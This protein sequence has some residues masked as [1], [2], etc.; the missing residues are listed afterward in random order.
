MTACGTPKPSLR[1]HH[2]RPA[3]LP[4][5]HARIFW[6]ESVKLKIESYCFA[7][8]IMVVNIF[9]ISTQ[10]LFTERYSFS[11]RKSVAWSSRSQYF[12][13]A[14]SFKAMDIFDTKSA[15]LWPCCASLIFAPILVPLRRSCLE[16]T[17]SCLSFCICW[18][19]FTLLTAKENAFS[20]TM[21]PTTFHFP[22]S[23]FNYEAFSEVTAPKST[24]SANSTMPANIELK[25]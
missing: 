12:V 5:R 21:L 9:S 23:T 2:L 15:L 10:S 16:R 1:W 4:F 14:V 11:V 22:F 20:D 17:Y 8:L 6:V 24:E 25:V 7:D 3:R 13:S 18:Q 19:S